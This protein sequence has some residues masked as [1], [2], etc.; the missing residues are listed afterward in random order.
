MSV[1]NNDRVNPS[2][3]TRANPSLITDNAPCGGDCFS[4]NVSDVW[5]PLNVVL[6]AELRLIA[7]I[8]PGMFWTAGV[9]FNLGAFTGGRG[10]GPGFMKRSLE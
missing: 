1:Q 3:L 7:L 4:L 8:L 10:A 9:R 2:S 6:L 5:D